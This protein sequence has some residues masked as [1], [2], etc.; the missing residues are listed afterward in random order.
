[1]SI[2]KYAFLALAL[3]SSVAKADDHCYKFYV[4][5]DLG[6]GVFSIKHYDNG[7]FDETVD[8]TLTTGVARFTNSSP[9]FIG[10][11]RIGLA[12]DGSECWYAAI[13]GNVHYAGR[14]MRGEWTA[15]WDVSQDVRLND[16]V[17]RF[18]DKTKFI[19]GVNAHLGYKFCNEAVV[20]VLGGYKYLKHDL[21]QNFSFGEESTTKLVFEDINSRRCL[22]SNGWTVGLGMVNNLWCDWDLRL[23]AAYAGFGSECV[24]N[25]F[26]FTDT[27]GDV[28]YTYAGNNLHKVQPRLFYGLASLSYNF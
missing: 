24:R 16:P 21:Y 20:Y 19:A 27:I 28:T 7:N 15:D 3:L 11:G 10:G 26:E 13:E 9:T 6:M 8:N 23:E 17:V 18:T 2:K 12:W 1:M 25:N 22:N 4:G 5:G 14:C